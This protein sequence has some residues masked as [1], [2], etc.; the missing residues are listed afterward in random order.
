MTTVIWLLIAVSQGSHNSGT[1]TP[2]AEYRSQENCEK[3]V[4]SV[5]H[6]AYRL[7]CI[8]IVKEER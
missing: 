5:K 8:K 7:E 4:G 3:S 1:V 2:I 6:R